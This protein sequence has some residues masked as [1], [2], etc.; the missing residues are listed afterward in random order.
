LAA[1]FDAVSSE[2]EMEDRIET[3]NQKID[4][5]SEVQ[6]TLRAL[7]TEVSHDRT[8]TRCQDAD[9]IAQGSAHRMEVIIIALIAVEVVLVSQVELIA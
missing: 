8:A 3:I 4:Y 9:Y 7:L 5:A 6:S 1:Y 2:F